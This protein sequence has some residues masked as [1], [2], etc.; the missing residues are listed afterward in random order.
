MDPG[1][2]ATAEDGAQTLESSSGSGETRTR[3]TCGARARGVQRAAHSAGPAMRFDR[4]VYDGIYVALAL[5]MEAPL[6]TA[7]RRLH[8]SLERTP[9]GPYLVW[10]EALPETN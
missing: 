3:W 4:S 8:N 7:D 2:A 6:V 9:L 10:V 5:A 1:V